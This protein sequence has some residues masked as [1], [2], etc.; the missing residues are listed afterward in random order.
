M[1]ANLEPEMKRGSF[2]GLEILIVGG[3]LGGLFAAVEMCRQGHQVRLLEG[4]EGIEGL[5]KFSVELPH[6]SSTKTN[7]SLTIF[8]R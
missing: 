8:T 4:K 2:T 3:G 6:Q 5:G 1:V 7:S